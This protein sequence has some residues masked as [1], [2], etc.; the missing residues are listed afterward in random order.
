L[1]IIT[2][3]ITSVALPIAII[4]ITARLSGCGSELRLCY[5]ESHDV[6]VICRGTATE[7]LIRSLTL[8]LEDRQIIGDYHSA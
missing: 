2:P 7:G 5:S 3:L 4:A 8:G 1:A 6:F